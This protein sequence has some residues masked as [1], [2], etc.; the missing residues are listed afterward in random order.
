MLVYF[1]V[2]EIHQAARIC[3]FARLNRVANPVVVLYKSADPILL[4]RMVNEVD[5]YNKAK[6]AIDPPEL[7]QG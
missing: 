7:A 1:M 3:R 4:V 5:S 6:D 2:R